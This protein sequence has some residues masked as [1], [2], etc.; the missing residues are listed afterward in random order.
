[1]LSKHYPNEY[2]LALNER[3]LIFVTLSSEDH[4]IH[5]KQDEK[6]FDSQ[7]VSSIEALDP[8]RIFACVEKVH[9][10]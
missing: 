1:M 10:V 9:N 3:G 4:K 2:A 6:Y 7:S 8:K 5:I